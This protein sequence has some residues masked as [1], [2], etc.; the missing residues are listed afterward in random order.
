MALIYK[1]LLCF[2]FLLNGE[3]REVSAGVAETPEQACEAASGRSF[4]YTATL[5]AGPVRYSEDAH[6]P[7]SILPFDTKQYPILFTCSHIHQNR[8]V[9]A[10]TNSARH[11]CTVF[12]PDGNDRYIFGLRKIVV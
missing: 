7:S 1:I 9:Y 10:T 3:L 8:I 6:L 12:T 4:E 2:V 11:A 5:S